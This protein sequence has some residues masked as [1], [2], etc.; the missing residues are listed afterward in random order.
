MLVFQQAL[1]QTHSVT[2]PLFSLFLSTSHTQTHSHT[3]LAL[4]PL[5]VTSCWSRIP[6]HFNAFLSLCLMPAHHALVFA[7]TYSPL[8]MYSVQ[9]RTYRHQ[10]VHY[11]HECIKSMFS[12]LWW[13][14]RVCV[15][16]PICREREKRGSMFNLRIA[17]VCWDESEQAGEEFQDAHEGVEGGGSWALVWRLSGS[18]GCLRPWAW[19]PHTLLWVNILTSGE[20]HP[21]PAEHWPTDGSVGGSRQRKEKHVEIW[22]LQR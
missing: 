16:V 15:C 12:L 1:G 17:F 2:L 14:Y 22:G 18:P 3:R 7:H 21:L 19:V 4:R 8:R 10:C 9:F 5:L 6:P 20:P 11:M 13:E